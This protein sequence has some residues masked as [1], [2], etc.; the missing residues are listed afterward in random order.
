VSDLPTRPARVS[1]E[2][3]ANF[4][5]STAW[6]RYVETHPEGRFSQ[7]FAYRCIEQV[8]GYR[9]HYFGI[10]SAGRL[11]GVLPTFEARSAFFGRRLVS[12]PFS[13]YGGMLLDADLN[14]DARKSVLVA[15]RSF[16][17]DNGFTELE[18]HGNYGCGPERTGFA[19]DNFQQLATLDLSGGHEAV[20]ERS[21]SR[22][23]RKAVRKAEREGL[24]TCEKSDDVALHDWFYPLYLRS[25][26]RLGA[27]PHSLEMFTQSRA[28]FGE[29]MRIYWALHEGTPVAGL[30]G[31]RCGQRVSIIN[32]VSDERYWQ[33]R[34]NDLV[35]WEFIK[36]ATE[37][38]CLH[39]DFGSVR[40]QGQ[41]Q[42][43]EKWGCEMQDS[44]YY[45]LAADSDSVHRSF[46][47]SSRSMSFAGKVWTRFVPPSI[48]RALGPTLRR[49]LVR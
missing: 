7:L 12:Q 30:L 3:V 22:H 38:G 35:H 36:W 19:R 16:L 47:S 39:F 1:V 37:S 40:Y 24:K 29:R 14:D 41:S 15:I 44:G 33:F 45:F 28:A 43:K 26:K 8:Y 48:A 18:T 21:V 13:E 4:R 32:I 20:W 42:F 6:D 9:A 49:H 46:D 11:V 23:V 5:D 2:V 31:F 10:Y 27:P 25:M 17:A 34:P